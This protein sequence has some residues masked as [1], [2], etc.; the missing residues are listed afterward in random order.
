[1]TSTILLTCG[2]I[3]LTT[4]AAVAQS[5][6]PPPAA[7]G[8]RLEQAAG[9]GVA[10]APAVE[11]AQPVAQAPAKTEWSGAKDPAVHARFQVRIMEGVLEKAVQQA[12]KLL[13]QQLRAV[14]PDLV[15]LTGAARAH[16]YRLDGYGMFFD[17]E[18]PAALRHSMGWTARMFK[19]SNE[20]IDRA[21]LSLK[22]ATG[23]LDGKARSEAETALRLIELQIR[24]AGTT[25]ISGVAR[26][27]DESPARTVSSTSPSAP[28][29]QDVPATAPAPT[30]MGPELAGPGP[31]TASVGDSQPP[32][33]NP[34]WVQNPDL[35][36]EVE[37]REALIRAM[38]EWG[39]LLPLQ[40]DEW[41][42]IAARD[43]QDVVI[44]GDIAEAVTIIM[45]VKG[46]D[47]AEVKAGRLSSADARQ[48]VEVREF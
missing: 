45:R 18:V 24:P 44:P 43:N 42:T 1:M 27:G 9:S 34:L 16:G 14:S 46:S 22:R 23:A 20:N 11:L 39:T 2:A 41:L 33:V 8:P 32:A 36:Y 25:V 29:A 5:I 6:T 35:A 12:A 37:V 7:A 38:L 19:Q 4:G 28:A 3:L 40:P 26:T 30:P 17:V 31:A 15:Q 21:L 47:L 48:R 13:N 10:Q